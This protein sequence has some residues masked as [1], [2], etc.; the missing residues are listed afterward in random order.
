MASLQSCIY[1]GRVHHHRYFPVNHAFEYTLF[2]MYLDLAE[3]P[4]LFKPFWF[5]SYQGRNLASF[6]TAD[7]FDGK[8]KDLDQSIRALISQET[9]EQ[10]EG[11]IRLLTHLRYFGFIFNPVS[12]Y[13]CF[14]KTD[15]RLAF[16]VAEITNTPWGERHRYV[17]N[18]NTALVNSQ[19]GDTPF[20]FQFEKSFHVSPFMPMNMQYD[21][22]FK[23]PAQA[24]FIHMENLQNNTKKF[25]ATL[26]L[27]RLEISHKTMAQ[28][29]LM[30]PLM[31]L[32]VTAAIYWQ[33]LKLW[34]KRVP[35]IPHP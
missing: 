16:I 17:L 26:L 25:D 34:L 19:N 33:A 11:P 1:T 7:Y 5:W 3:L 23:T 31:T 6:F 12:F 2:M 15:T 28:V 13:Y 24:L 20:Q 8:A 18:C 9:G 29:L 27:T 32:K 22:R 10:A 14:D 21:W 35:Y 4:S 30:Y